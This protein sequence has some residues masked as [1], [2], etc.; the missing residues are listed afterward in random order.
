MLQVDMDPARV[1]AILAEARRM[2]A[3]V[4]RRLASALFSGPAHALS[5]A[6]VYVRH[7]MAGHRPNFS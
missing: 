4:L 3:N 1:S 7:L 5:G 2:R 6:A